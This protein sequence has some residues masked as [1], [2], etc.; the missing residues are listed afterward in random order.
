V[1]VA[2]LCVGWHHADH[3]LLCQAQGSSPV[4]ASVAAQQATQDKK[5]LGFIPLWDCKVEP[6][7]DR[8]ISHCFEVN[9]PDRR[10]FYMA[11]SPRALSLPLMLL[12]V[13]VTTG[14]KEMNEWVEVLRK[15]VRDGSKAR[16]AKVATFWTR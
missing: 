9:H 14:P 13:Q 6:N 3:V 16:K 12:L 8:E 15:C 5:P 7:Q 11:S 10:T 1:E 4:D 2:V